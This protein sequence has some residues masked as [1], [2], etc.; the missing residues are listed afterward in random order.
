MSDKTLIDPLGRALILHDLTWDGHIIA[1]HPEVARH[2]DLVEAA[3]TSPICIR[4]SLRDPD[5]RLY[6]GLGPRPT[7][8][9]QV[10]ADIG[11]GVVKTAHLAGRI[12]GGSEEWS[13]PTP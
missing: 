3:I 8:K 6:Y 10:V 2:R 12:S 1:G 9:I 4:L 5:C 13:S 11:L 7:V